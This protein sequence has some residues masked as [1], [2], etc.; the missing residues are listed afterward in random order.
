[1]FSGFM[2][3]SV[4]LVLLSTCIC[5]FFGKG[6]IKI[7]ELLNCDFQNIFLLQKCLIIVLEMAVRY[8]TNSNTMC[9]VLLNISM[10]CMPKGSSQLS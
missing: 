2:H 5:L 4:E 9:K 10:L 1:M 6:D 7:F 8:Q 3:I